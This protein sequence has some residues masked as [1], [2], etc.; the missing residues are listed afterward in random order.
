M[1]R[2]GA[3]LVV[4]LVFTCSVAADDWEYTLR[5]GDELWSI[6]RDYCGSASLAGAIASHNGLTNVAAVRAGQRIAIPTAWLV[7]AP[8]T[9]TVLQVSGDARIKRGAAPQDPEVPAG[10]GDTLL[11]GYSIITGEGAALVE[12]A[13]GSQL[14]V[15]PDS[16]VLFNKLTAF[17][18]AGMV[19][20]HLRFAYGR[21]DARVQP[22]NRGDRFRIQTPQGIAAVRGTE[23]R[24]AHRDEEDRSNSETLEGLVAFLRPD[25]NTDLPA[26]FGVAAGASGVVKEALLEAPQWLEQETQTAE[27]AVIRWRP[28]AGAARYVITWAEI[29]QPDIAVAQTVTDDASTTVVVPPGQ[30]RLGVRGVSANAIEGYDA[31][32]VLTVRARAP[33]LT[34]VTSS[35]SGD[36]AFAWQYSEPG[37]RFAL[38]LE[39]DHFA[40]AKRFESDTTGYQARLPAGAYRWRVQATNSA[41]S[42]TGAF[43]LLPPAPENLR[44]K[45]RDK[46]LFFSWTGADDQT[47]VLRVS[48]IDG[49]ASF[50]KTVTGNSAEIDVDSYGDYQMRL[51]SVQNSLQSEALV[52]P[53][54]V[55][56][57][58]WW[59]S[60]LIPLIV[61]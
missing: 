39:A 44:I 35:L 2:R 3:L 59:M 5:P 49:G 57:R 54:Q 26:G 21:G 27:Q 51:A 31:S 12:F 29:S 37:A 52:Y 55:F 34:A 23:F 42:E 4:L 41:P 38:T 53:I 43:T 22:Q 7:F 19:D 18:P 10:S 15:Q 56:K 40:D 33:Q 16:R 17:G 61:L 45:R 47:Y 28:L 13:D 58:P 9:A 46:R 11:M 48:R 60:L 8:A 25:Q 50:E 6:A 30:Y 20:T 24:V 32:R 1:T 36:V 14:S